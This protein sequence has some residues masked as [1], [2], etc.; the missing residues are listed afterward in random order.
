MKAFD[1][2]PYKAL[3]VYFRCVT[4]VT[5]R[6]DEDERVMIELEIKLFLVKYPEFIILDYS[7]V[8]SLGV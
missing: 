2:L 4:A 3:T 5:P 1:A 8:I 6:R 7:S